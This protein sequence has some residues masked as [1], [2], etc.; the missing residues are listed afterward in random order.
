MS[1]IDTALSQLLD[2]EAIR[3]LPVRY[4]DCVWQGD[5]DGLVKLF[6]DDGVFVIKMGDKEVRAE[7]RSALL[8]FYKEGTAHLPRPYIHNHVVDQSDAKNASG[9]CYLDLR[10]AKSNMEWIGAGFYNDRYVKTDSGWRFASRE[11]NVL[12][13]DEG[14]GS[15]ES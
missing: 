3:D 1:D 8:D 15:D 13:I 5:I 14:P 7:G 12:R 6:A 11:F 4:C 2:R 9:R 10:S